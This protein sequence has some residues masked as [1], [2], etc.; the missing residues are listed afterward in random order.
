MR[1]NTIC[2]PPFA[3]CFLLSAD[4]PLPLKGRRSGERDLRYT[5]LLPTAL[6]GGGMERVLRR[7]AR[8]GQ[9]VTS[10]SERKN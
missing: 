10:D 6:E 4:C 3:F 2:F 9:D 8:P 5:R 1:I 7:H